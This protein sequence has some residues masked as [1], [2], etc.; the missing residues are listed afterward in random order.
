MPH[1]SRGDLMK[2][3]IFKS[4]AIG[5]L[6]AFAGDPAGSR[7]PDKFRPWHAVGVVAPLSSPPYKLSR[8]QIEQAIDSQGFQLWRMKPKNTAA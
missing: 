1:S 3:Y 7:L 8:A 2:L 6:R 4:E 5:E